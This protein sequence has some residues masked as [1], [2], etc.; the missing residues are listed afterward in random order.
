[1]TTGISRELPKDFMSDLMSGSLMPVLERVRMD[2]T[3]LLALRGTYVNVYYRGGNLMRI[4]GPATDS[5]RSYEAFFDKKYAES[6]RLLPRPP[7]KIVTRKD[8]QRW[9][10][11]FPRLKQIMDT[12]FQTKRKPEREFQQLAARENNCSTISVATEYFVTD[13]EVADPSIGARFDMLALRWPA[14]ARKHGRGCQAALIEMKYGDDALKGESGVLEHL[15]D[16]ERLARDE[17][18][19]RQLRK[20]A[21]DQFRQLDELGLLKFR[22][23][24]RV[25]KI[26]LKERL[27]VI[28]V[29]ANLN[30]RS[31][32][33]TEILEDRR[34]RG[35]ESRA[36]PF[37]LRFFVAHFAGYGMH[38][39]CM[40]TLDQLKKRM[41]RRAREDAECREYC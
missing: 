24:A 10:D 9:V 16:M 32:V 19:C 3:L 36:S 6:P 33:L 31:G 13:I 41:G 26:E 11:A 23:S 8:A 37:D 30:P 4:T 27:E 29:L 18:K 38:T 14:D 5:I 34:M 17:D 21:E 22:R 15:H 40:L 7:G 28:L 2:D 25:T 35:F 1:M 20:A 39:D 12:H